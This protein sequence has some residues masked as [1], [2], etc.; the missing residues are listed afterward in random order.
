MLRNP[1]WLE[2]VSGQKVLDFGAFQ[3]WRLGML[4]L[5]LQL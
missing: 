3:I 2:H 4:N 1:E 5:Y